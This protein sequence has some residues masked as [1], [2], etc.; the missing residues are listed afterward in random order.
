MLKFDV[1]IWLDVKINII[2]VLDDN[3]DFIIYMDNNILSWM[4]RF[5][6]PE[7]TTH[8][9]RC[10]ALYMDPARSKEVKTCILRLGS[11]RRITLVD[12]CAV[13]STATRW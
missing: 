6:P 9:T 3:N 4:I 2:I 1:V 13:S 5:I 11:R 8:S 7:N 10:G 12:Y